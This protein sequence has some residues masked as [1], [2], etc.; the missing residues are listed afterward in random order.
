MGH[1]RYAKATSGYISTGKQYT[2]TI[3]GLNRLS[4]LEAVCI[5]AHSG[6]TLSEAALGCAE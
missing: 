4:Q 2:Y 3:E 1:P 5:A 6:E